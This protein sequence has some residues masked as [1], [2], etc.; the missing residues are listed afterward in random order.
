MDARDGGIVSTF[1]DYLKRD[2]EHVFFNVDELAGL[3][4]LNG[5]YL[6]AVT[7]RYTERLTDRQSDQYEGL[8]GDHLMVQCRAADVLK[9]VS[10]LPKENERVQFDG[11]WYDVLS[12]E[13][14]YG[15]LR[16]TL[17]SYRG[18]YA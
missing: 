15:V 6:H 17:T 10:E 14:E 2:V 7:Q 5:I 4:N 12:S 11:Q 16:L 9:K 3:H 8:H 1:K 13:N 18:T